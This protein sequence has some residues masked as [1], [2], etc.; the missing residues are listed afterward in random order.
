MAG[1]VKAKDWE[2]GEYSLGS[3]ISTT[4]LELAEG[5]TVNFA[6]ARKEQREAIVPNTTPDWE[7]TIDVIDYINENI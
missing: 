7:A 3:G 6:P 5:K 2:A 1:L 4:V